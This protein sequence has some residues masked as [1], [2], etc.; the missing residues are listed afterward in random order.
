LRLWCGGTA[1][2]LGILGG[3]NHG[4]ENGRGKSEASE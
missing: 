1:G 2:W 4:A 3:G